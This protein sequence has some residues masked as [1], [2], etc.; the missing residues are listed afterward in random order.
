MIA[1]K[2]DDVTITSWVKSKLAGDPAFN[3]RQIDVDTDEGTVYLIG[4]V[5]SEDTRVRAEQLARGVNGVKEVVN[6]LRVRQPQTRT[7]TGSQGSQSQ[8]FRKGRTMK[9]LKDVGH[10]TGVQFTVHRSVGSDVAT[11]FTRL[12]LERGLQRLLGRYDYML[13][14]RR[15]DEGMGTKLQAVEVLSRPEKKEAPR[16]RARRRSPRRRSPRR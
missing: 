7:Q 5:S 2:I 16:K 3:L 11:T 14:Y 8:M 13:V 15:T 10:Q 1:Q 6:G 4:W 9:V 12:P